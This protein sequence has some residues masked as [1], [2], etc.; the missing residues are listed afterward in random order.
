MS[1]EKASILPPLRACL[2]IFR[3]KT[4]EGFQYR[5]AGLAGAS[6]SIFWVLIEITVYT[7][8]YTYAN[9]KNAGMIAGMSLPH[10]VSYAW[11]TQLFFLMQPMNIDGE[12]LTKITSGDVAIELCRPLDLYFHWFAKSAASRLTPLLWRG[13]VTIVVGLI[14]PL[15]YRLTPPASLLGF[16]CMMLSFFSAFLLCTSFAMLAVA[17]RLNISLGEGPT[18]IIMLVGGVLSGGYLPLQL[19]PKFMQGFLL[20]QPFAGYLDI[21]LRFY[22]GTLAPG[23]AFWAIGLQLFWTAVFVALGRRLINKRLKNIIVQGG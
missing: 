20:I 13:S 17:V 6:T 12:I 15:S 21:P 19:W 5:M 9:D 4:A 22:I 23:N 8:F 11:L 14:M 18:Y 3:I 1:G 2:S 16:A 10:L 7:I